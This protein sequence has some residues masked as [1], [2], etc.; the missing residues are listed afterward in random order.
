[1]VLDPN[2]K[3][4]VALGFVLASGSLLHGQPVNVRGRVANASGQ[5][6]ANAV[7]ELARQGAKDTTGAD[8]TF[9]I[10]ASGT[11]NR[12]LSA[13][14]AEGIRLD[15]GRLE[16]TVGKPSPLKVEVF[17]A[18]G[19]L[20][21]IV[22]LPRAEPGVYHSDISGLSHAKGM[23]IVKASIGP[24]VRTFRC[25]APQE[26]IARGNSQIAGSGPAVG[27]L[28]K[29]AAAVDTLRVSAAGYLPEKVGL[30]SYDTSVD[31]TLVADATTVY[32]PCPTN[33]TSCKILPFGDSITR[34]AKSSDDGG[35]RSP[36]FK[37]IVAAGQKAT[38]TG[39]QAHGPAQVSGRSFPRAHEGRAGWTIDPGFN[40]NSSS[41]GGISSLV[42][43]P[44]LN[45]A[46]H[47][48]LL[49][50]GT[51]DLFA[52]ETANMAA[53]LEALID[54]IAKNAPDALIVLA[55]ITPLA[56]ANAALTAYND[57]IP[58]IVRSH[59]AKGRHIIAV[60]MGGLPRT[61]LSDGT[62]PNDSGYAYMAGVWYA[63]IKDLL[64]R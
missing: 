43:S 10:I 16:F 34:G 17:D 47:I 39:S 13:M 45:G 18:S 19:N 23:L 3:R 58:G 26:G 32:N 22:S 36:L 1:M 54:K 59:A 46:P 40:M 56:S 4:I 6:V 11:P 29:R 42:P 33:G 44:A 9:S 5:P 63:A 15:Q 51:N 14:Q 37:L 25:F 24:L 38:F 27:M 7:V 57:K 48:I 64:P 50:I 30:S 61:G 35:Y 41:Y 55:Q 8:G 60:D 52:R 62:H 28:T 21:K 31:I 12:S 2:M 49:H 53:R 20:R